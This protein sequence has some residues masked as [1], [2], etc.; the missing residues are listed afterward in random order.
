MRALVHLESYTNVRNDD[1]DDDG[2]D[3][4]GDKKCRKW[5]ARNIWT[6]MLDFDGWGKKLCDFFIVRN[7]N[8]NHSS[9]RYA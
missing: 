1:D 7:W 5:D 3:G 6:A 2:G 4:N 8:Q 9:F